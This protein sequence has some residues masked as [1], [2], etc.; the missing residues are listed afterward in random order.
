MMLAM[1][2]FFI[3]FAS[4]LILPSLY[5]VNKYTGV[6]GVFLYGMLVLLLLL[7]F[8]KY[9]LKKLFFRITERRAFWLIVITLCFLIAIFYLCYPIANSGIFGPGSDR[10]ED[11]NIS[12]SALLHGR[13]P[14]YVKTY[15]GN[16][17]THL[18]GSLFLSAPFVLLGNGAYQNFFWILL[19]LI[20]LKF[21]LGSL[22]LALFLLWLLF[23][24]SPA[25][26]HELITGGDLIAN[27]LYIL[28][29]IFLTIN[30]VSNPHSKKWKKVLSA[31]LLGIGLSSRANFLFLLPLIFSALVQNAGYRKAVGY[32]ML[33]GA[34]FAAVTL[35]FYLYDPQNFTPLYV[36]LMKIKHFDSALPFASISIILIG[37]ITASLL[38]FRRMNSD[39]NALFRNCALVQVSL[40]A[41]TAILETISRGTLEFSFLGYGLSFLFFAA[42]PLWAQLSR[43]VIHCKGIE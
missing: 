25:L 28:I 16:Q 40:M 15:L 42:V 12:T 4:F 1:D 5:V 32:I 17:I 31:I 27:S 20:M 35:P 37:A 43:G 10:D 26:L 8:S 34:V 39:C 23:I 2:W 13:Y 6:A 9:F 41:S 36:Q 21:H 29:F 19:F 30:T 14:Y 38:S 3:K 11:M 18:P 7:A 22:R 33:T 24:L